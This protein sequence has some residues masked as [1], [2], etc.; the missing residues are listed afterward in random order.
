MRNKT[1]PQS[2]SA[3]PTSFVSHDDMHTKGYFSADLFLD[4]WTSPYVVQKCV[5]KAQTA[6]CHELEIMDRRMVV[7]YI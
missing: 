6:N 3:G 1:S 4:D 2:Y 5:Y 7:L